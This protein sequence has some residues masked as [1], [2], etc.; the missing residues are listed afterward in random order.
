[1]AI[2]GPKKMTD[3]S[4]EIIE[5]FYQDA[6]GPKGDT[7]DY[8]FIYDKEIGRGPNDSRRLHTP[9]GSGVTLGAGYDLSARTREQVIAD[10]L[11]VGV[12]PKL[13][14]HVAQYAGPG[15]KGID[16]INQPDILNEA[17]EQ[18][19]FKLE[20]ARKEKDIDRLVKV[21]LTGNERSA[22][23]SLVYNVGAGKLAESDALAALNQGD[24]EGF[25]K[26]AF[27]PEIGFVKAVKGGKPIP[28]LV[29]RRQEEKRI[30]AG[31][32]GE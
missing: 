7:P 20:I 32:L 27:D 31:N 17:Q 24:K 26:H 5:R 28:S 25:M 8:S 13:A 18:A 9:A 3:L 16:L 10:L 29:E 14:E 30:F 19:L 1:M 23:M 15:D 2:L 6:Y 21:P 12:Q 4:G 11:D 22:I